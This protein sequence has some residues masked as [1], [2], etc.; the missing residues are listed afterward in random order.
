[1][2]LYPRIGFVVA[3]VLLLMPFQASAIN[4]WLNLAGFILGAALV[5]V[6]ARA[7]RTD[8]VRA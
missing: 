4:A 6:E 3:G 7:R 2:G 1:M 5:T 8:V